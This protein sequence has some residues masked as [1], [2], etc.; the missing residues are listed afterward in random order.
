MCKEHHATIDDSK[1]ESTYTPHLLRQWKMAQEE[2]W[3]QALLSSLTAGLPK[4]PSP[5]A[6]HVERFLSY[7][8]G[9]AQ[10]RVPFGGREAV[11]EG[12]HEKPWEAGDR[13]AR[14]RLRIWQRSHDGGVRCALG[15][16]ANDIPGPARVG[17]ATS[18]PQFFMLPDL[19]GFQID[20]AMNIQATPPIWSGRRQ[21]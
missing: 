9:T 10:R 16:A 13:V 5:C 14:C 2:E 6:T 12:E 8:L 21:P 11:L 19:A 4:I 17:G 7:Y 15:I 20:C 18:L 3:R 1:M